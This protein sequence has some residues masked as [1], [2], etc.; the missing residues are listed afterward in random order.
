MVVCD[1]STKIQ[2][3]VQDIPYNGQHWPRSWQVNFVP[4]IDSPRQIKA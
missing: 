4:V 1:P 3:N 2:I